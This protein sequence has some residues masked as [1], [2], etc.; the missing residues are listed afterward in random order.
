MALFLVTYR[1][2]S[3]RQKIYLCACLS[4]TRHW[5]RQ[6]HYSRGHADAM[7]CGTVWHLN[8]FLP[9]LLSLGSR[10]HTH[11]STFCLATAIP[12][13]WSGLLRT[14]TAQHQVSMTT[15][16]YLI[17]IFCL[18]YVLIPNM[19]ALLCS[20]PL[21]GSPFHNFPLSSICT[22]VCTYIVYDVFTQWTQWF[23]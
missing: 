20:P 9:L 18:H 2:Q 6:S 15:T 5:D 22:T 3:H 21:S 23:I 11:N 17:C 4:L 13:M 19:V 1:H 10:T 12:Q 7:H 8:F 16:P 14:T